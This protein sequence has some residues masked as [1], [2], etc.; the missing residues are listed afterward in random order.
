MII[1]DMENPN[2]LTV[3]ITEMGTNQNESIA[4]TEAWIFKSR[5]IAVPPLNL[6]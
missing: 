3:M 2:A 5:R 6:K 4:A 1:W